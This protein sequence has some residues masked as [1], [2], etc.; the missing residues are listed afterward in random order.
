MILNFHGNLKAGTLGG[1]LLSIVSSLSFSDVERTVILGAIG[2]TVSFFISMLLRWIV[3]LV[4]SKSNQ[5]FLKRR[6]KK[7]RSKK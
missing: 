2:A 5:L 4:R 1:A 6:K 3:E 7:K